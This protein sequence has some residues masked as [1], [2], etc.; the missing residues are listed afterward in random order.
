VRLP[1]PRNVLLD[2]FRWLRM[3]GFA[4]RCRRAFS[5]PS[6][7]RRNVTGQL[8]DGL[9]FWIAPSGAIGRA[10]LLSFTGAALTEALHDV[11]IVSSTCLETVMFAG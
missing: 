5:M 2:I 3:H 1:E 11:M 10:S 7:T 6:A 8:P 9:Q 4:A